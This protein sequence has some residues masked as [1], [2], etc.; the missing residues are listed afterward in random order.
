MDSV[1]EGADNTVDALAGALETLRAMRDTPTPNDDNQ[2]EF[3]LTVPDCKIEIRNEGS[4]NPELY[5]SGFIGF[6]TST[7]RVSQWLQ[8][9]T[10]DITI[11][12][13]S[14]GGDAWEGLA[15]NSLIRNYSK[16]KATTRIDGRASSAA[17][18]IFL[19]GDERL[20]MDNSRLMIHEASIFGYVEGTKN[21]VK[22]KMENILKAMDEVN[23]AIAQSIVNATGLTLA[24]AKGLVT[25]SDT[26]YA[27][28][29]AM[30]NK[31]ATKIVSPK[32]KGG[33][34]NL[35]NSSETEL[36]DNREFAS[37]ILENIFEGFG[38]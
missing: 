31:L 3:A 37:A 25:E 16:G 17:A 11:G 20:M 23:G 1:G 9:Q 15:I 5:I 30:D 8:D 21:K 28:K 32:K 24:K 34:T 22:Q 38:V 19:A 7:E 10:G 12:I 26:Y 36:T 14:G 6:R 29:S 27:A 18:V 35:V 13:N 4:D 33:S 2:Q